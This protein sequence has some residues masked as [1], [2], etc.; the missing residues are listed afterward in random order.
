MGTYIWWRRDV[1]IIEHGEVIRAT[2]LKLGILSAAGTQNVTLSYSYENRSFTVR[3][4]ISEVAL[5]DKIVGDTL[6]IIIDR[7]NPKRFIAK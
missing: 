4:S 1:G 7:R 3:K 2:I 5:H 6:P